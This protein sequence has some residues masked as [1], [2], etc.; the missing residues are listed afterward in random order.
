MIDCD[1][2]NM[3]V[4]KLTK[5]LDAVSCTLMTNRNVFAGARDR[6]W[7]DWKQR[8]DNWILH[9]NYIKMFYE[10]QSSLDLFSFLNWNA[11]LSY[12][13]DIIFTDIWELRRWIFVLNEMATIC[14]CV[15]HMTLSVNRV[16]S[17]RSVTA[18]TAHWYYI[19][20]KKQYYSVLVHPIAN[21]LTQDCK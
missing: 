15:I 6:T 10:L 11:L 20:N 17:T 14:W 18:D 3:I 12:W 9:C 1:I 2:K 5:I 8:A 16:L 21:I 19:K 4:Y 7:R 13:F